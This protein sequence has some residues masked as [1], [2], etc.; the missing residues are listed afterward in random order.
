MLADSVAFYSFKIT[1][2]EVVKIIHEL[3]IK[4]TSDLLGMA[5]SF[6]VFS[7]S[8]SDCGQNK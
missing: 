7:Y 3:C 2:E 1:A 8:R 6:F 5:K 4:L